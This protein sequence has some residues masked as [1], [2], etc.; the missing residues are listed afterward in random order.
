MNSGRKKMKIA[1]RRTRSA[2]DERFSLTV[3][4]AVPHSGLPGEIQLRSWARAALQR[5]VEQ[6]EISLRIVDE[7]EG[8]QLNHDYR[9]RDNAT[10][11]L[12]FALNEGETIAGLPLFGDI[13]LTAPVVERE[14]GEQQK[15]LEAHYAHLVI[16]SMLH[17]QGF[18]HIEEEEAVAMETLETVILK[19]LGYADPYGEEHA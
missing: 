7:A 9:G 4:Y 19:R 12:T 1:K 2:I 13:V 15:T 10:N 14:A 11:V 8:R 18:D 6:A 5:G 17:L 3:D 16:H